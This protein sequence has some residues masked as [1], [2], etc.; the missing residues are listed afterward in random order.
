MLHDMSI[1]EPSSFYRCRP[2]P[3]AHLLLFL[4]S[5]FAEMSINASP[6]HLSACEWRIVVK[7]GPHYFSLYETA[8]M[9]TFLV[10]RISDVCR[11]IFLPF[12]S[13]GNACFSR[14]FPPVWRT[15]WKSF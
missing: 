1:C 14:P 10:K 3:G 7:P 15:I 5:F 4:F 8:S 2:S 11:A 13:F 9:G 6:V 12:R